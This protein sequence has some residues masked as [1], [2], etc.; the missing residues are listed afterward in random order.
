[1]DR[2]HI[3]LISFIQ[4][5]A[6][7]KDL[8]RAVTTA[9]RAKDYDLSAVFMR[10]WDTKDELGADGICEWEKDWDDVQKVCKVYDIPCRMVILSFYLTHDSRY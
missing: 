10:N 1:M 8:E 9:V 3:P 6:E 2:R 4:F 5:N 7:I